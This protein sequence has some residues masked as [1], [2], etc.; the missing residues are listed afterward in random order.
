[1]FRHFDTKHKCD[2]QTHRQIEMLYQIPTLPTLAQRCV[3]NNITINTHYL[4]LFQ[5]NNF[6]VLVTLQ[7]IHA[8]D[9]IVGQFQLLKDPKSNVCI[10]TDVIK[11]QCQISSQVSRSGDNVKSQ[12]YRR[13]VVQEYV[14]KF[15]LK[16]QG[17]RWYRNIKHSITLRQHYMSRTQTGRLTPEMT[18]P[19]ISLS[20]TKCCC[21]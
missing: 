16:L 20:H 5:I 14:H 11:P 8:T 17:H 15:S 12:A 6:Q 19:H 1:M 4:I 9:F 18:S 21:C 7:S 3:G 13:Y 2:T 10:H